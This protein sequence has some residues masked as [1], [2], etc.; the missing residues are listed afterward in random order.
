MKY[1]C[2]NNRHLVCKPYSIDNLHKMAEQFGIKRCWLHK[3]HYDITKR[4]VDEIKGLC[5]VVSS[6][7]IAKIVGRIKR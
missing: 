7:D 6:K 4:S 3:D 2:D 5:E 1:Y